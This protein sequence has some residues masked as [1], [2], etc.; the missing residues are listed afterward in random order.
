MCNND[1]IQLT[2]L[3]DVIWSCPSCHNQSIRYDKIKKLFV[4]WVCCAIL[5][6][7]EGHKQLDGFGNYSPEG[8]RD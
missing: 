1:D 8:N 3:S 7:E 4:C 5:T 6:E 2:H